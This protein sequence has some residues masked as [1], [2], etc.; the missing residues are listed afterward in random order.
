MAL[1]VLLAKVIGI[2][3][4]VIGALIII[5]RRYFL[6]IFAAY[7]E[8]RLLRTTMSMIE[9]L[10][11]IFLVVG[12]NVWS[13]L[14]AALITI[15]GWMAVFE[16]TIY[17]LLPDRWVAKFI[18]TFNTAGWYIVGGSLA[19]AVGGYLSWFGFTGADAG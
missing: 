13:P 1:T 17:L 5:R 2:M 3:L 18:A 9:L 14:P 8:Q 15:I 16:A 19:I 7:V 10:A 11:G 12:H 6:P 4:V